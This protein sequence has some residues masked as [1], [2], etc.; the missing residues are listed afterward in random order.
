M[1]FKVT[2]SEVGIGTWPPCPTSYIIKAQW[3]PPTLLIHQDLNWDQDQYIGLML[4]S[5][6]ST[7]VMDPSVLHPPHRNSQ[8][9]Q[10]GETQIRDAGTPAPHLHV[11]IHHPLVSQ[12]GSAHGLSAPIIT[13]TTVWMDTTT[14]LHLQHPKIQIRHNT[15]ILPSPLATPPCIRLNV[16]PS[17]AGG[18]G[19]LINDLV[20]H[21]PSLRHMHWG[22]WGGV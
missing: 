15:L 21:R 8:P 7:G 3:T 16:E 22:P 6:P 20:Q 5:L 1:G 18:M 2:G 13:L 4:P 17:Q 10:L 9:Q 14:P 11:L 19:L 12:L